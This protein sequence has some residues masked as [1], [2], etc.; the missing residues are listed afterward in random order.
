MPD[1]TMH[2]VE[3]LNEM[4]RSLGAR[5][6]VCRKASGQTLKAL[7]RR[8]GLSISTLSRIENGLLSITYDNMILIATALDLELV[9]LLRAEDATSARRSIVRSL[10]RRRL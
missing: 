2:S 1:T 4:T 7:A 10:T 5:I 8:T 6:S 3:T 9:D